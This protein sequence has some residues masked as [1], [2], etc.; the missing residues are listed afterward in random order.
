MMLMVLVMM[1]MMLVMMLMMLVMMVRRAYSASAR[2]ADIQDMPCTGIRVRTQL[3][4]I[5]CQ[6]FQIFSAQPHPRWSGFSTVSPS[7]LRMFKLIWASSFLPLHCA[8]AMCKILQN[9]KFHCIAQCIIPAHTNHSFLCTTQSTCAR[10]EPYFVKWNTHF[11]LNAL[12]FLVYNKPRDH[13][14]EEK[15]V[16]LQKEN[17]P[18]HLFHQ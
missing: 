2:G 10:N 6:I 14:D 3:H 11:C 5:L 18:L 9:A 13:R 7:L 4:F 15:R 17:S 16:L 8:C 1:V 12:H